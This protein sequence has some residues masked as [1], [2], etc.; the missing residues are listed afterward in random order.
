MKL[1]KTMLS[2]SIVAA[3]GFAGNAFAQQATAPAQ[4]PAASSCTMYVFVPGP[5]IMPGLP[6]VRRH[7]R[8]DS[9]IACPG[10]SA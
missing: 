6:A 1:R 8:G 7:T 9:R 2:A 5:V 10:P 3:L 4:A